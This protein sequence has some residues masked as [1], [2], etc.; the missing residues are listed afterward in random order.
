MGW[1]RT[2]GARIEVAIALAACALLA[3]APGALAH[4]DRV[5]TLVPTGLTATHSTAHFVLHYNPATASAGYVQAGAADFEE[6]YSRLVSGGGGS[7]NAGLDPPLN[8]GDAKTD[9]YIARPTIY[10][11]MNGGIV[12][13]DTGGHVPQT[14]YAF[15]TPGQDRQGFRFRAAHEFMHVIQGAYNSSPATDP[16][17][18]GIANWA[19]EFSLPDIDPGDNNFTTPWVPLDCPQP[20]NVW[21]G[22]SCGG[23]YGTW[24]FFQHMAEAY[25]GAIIADYYFE[26]KNFPS[27]VPTMLSS[28]ITGQNPFDSV[29]RHFADFA[30]DIWEP[31]RWKSGA[32]AR[33]HGFEGH[34]AAAEYTNANG[35]SG[36]QNA[37]VDHLAARYVRAITDLGFVPSGP[38]DALRFTVNTPGPVET[39]YLYMFGNR[40]PLFDA[41]PQTG[42]AFT[43]SADPAQVKQYVLPLIN[44]TTATD[45]LNYTYRVEYLPGTPTPPANDERAGAISIPLNQAAS[46]ESIYAG[47]IGANEAPGC[48]A[49]A[50][51]T[52][53]VWF[54]VKTAAQG[55]SYT[56]DATSSD[57][58]AV[59]SIHDASSGAFRGCA[60]DA[61]TT[62]TLSSSETY[63]IYVGRRGAPGGGSLAALTVSGP[64]EAAAQRKCKSKRKKGK[65][66]GRAAK[67]RKKSKCKK[68]G[69]KKKGKGKSAAAR[70]DELT[71]ADEPA[72]LLGGRK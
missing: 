69:R 53:G 50:G 62:R 33:I 19:A 34:P 37:D 4:H 17:L 56:F 70:F 21:E 5:G 41:A 36:L 59:L 1:V 20:A 12:F 2:T 38:N 58:P 26:V 61:S 3:T 14:S 32:I 18:E 16:I 68:K 8:D 46:G 54:K 72:P 44:D 6:A 30:R 39:P 52:R 67:K 15:M 11:N 22:T 55:G 27:S 13:Y 51:A 47:G 66:K 43:V 64:G 63:D 7:P 48:S 24:P 10:P 9:V 25:G 49:A 29:R 23:N 28:A 71:L 31:S 45:N 57:F 65:K 40:G 42:P 35:D 60:A